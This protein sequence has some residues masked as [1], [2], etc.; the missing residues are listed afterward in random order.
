MSVDDYLTL[1]Y[2]IETKVIPPED[3]G[4]VM[5]CMPELGRDSCLGDGET[6]EEA[7]DNLKKVQRKLFKFA[8]EKGYDIPLPEYHDISDYSG[9]FVVRVPKELHMRLSTQAKINETSLNS[10]IN[11][12]LTKAAGKISSGNIEN[13]RLKKA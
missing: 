9:R 12:L 8:L 11:Y 5:M 10:W 13:I 2:A 1:D 3:G 6:F 7:Y 4:G